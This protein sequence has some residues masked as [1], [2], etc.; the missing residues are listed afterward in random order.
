MALVDEAE[1]PA[2]KAKADAAIRELASSGR[3][4]TAEDLRALVG[5]PLRPNSM[6]SAFQRAARAGLVKYIRHQKSNRPSLQS[7]A[8][9]VW[10][11]VTK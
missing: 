2:W 1:N 9:R 5:D 7:C 10:V 8:I 6:G 3:E 11:G 4:F